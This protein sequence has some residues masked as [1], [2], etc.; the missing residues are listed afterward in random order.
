MTPNID[1]YRVGAVPKLYLE[2]VADKGRQRDFVVRSDLN[3]A[4]CGFPDEGLLGNPQP[5]HQD[6]LVME[7]KSVI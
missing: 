1:C 7:V 5:H 6:L 4:I 3:R 2:H